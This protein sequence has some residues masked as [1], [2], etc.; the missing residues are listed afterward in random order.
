[1]LL[2]DI[3]SD[4]RGVAEISVD[5]AQVLIREV[6]D[7]RTYSIPANGSFLTGEATGPR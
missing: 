4:F 5:A 7:G 2:V 1:M 6:G 3:P